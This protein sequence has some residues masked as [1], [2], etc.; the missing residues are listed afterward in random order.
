VSA[1]EIA[2][3]MT[4]AATLLGVIGGIVV[5]LRNSRKLEDVHQSTDGKMDALIT[6]VRAASFAKG[7]KSETDKHDDRDHTAN[8]DPVV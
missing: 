3:L 5:S 1:G 6:E 4:S 2:Q 7:V 8:S